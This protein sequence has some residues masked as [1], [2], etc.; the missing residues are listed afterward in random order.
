MQIGRRST[1]HG[2]ERRFQYIHRFLFD[3][4]HEGSHMKAT[5]ILAAALLI[6]ANGLTLAQA[7]Q[8]AIGRTEVVRHDLVTPGREAIQVRV[9]FGPGASF[10]MH[11]H[12]GE[13]IAYV[14]EGTLEYQFEG[15]PPVTLKAGDSLFIPAGAAHAARN[16]GSGKASELAT[17]LV[18]KGKPLV[19]VK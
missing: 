3:L 16:V 10:G 8:P 5:R 12:P 18:D 19:A 9:D 14:L 15:K 11:T 7:Q 2:Y 4:N 17:Y 13:E 6:A 1:N